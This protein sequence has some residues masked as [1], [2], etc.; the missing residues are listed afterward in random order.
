M[1]CSI[2]FIPS[3]PL[4]TAC[5]AD[6]G[7][8][9]T[10]QRVPSLNL[11]VKISLPIK[12][13]LQAL[14][15]LSEPSQV[16]VP[17]V[18]S[19]G[20]SCGSSQAQTH[21]GSKVPAVPAVSPSPCFS[22]SNVSKISRVSSLT[23]PVASVTPVTP[24]TSVPSKA[25]FGV[26]GSWELSETPGSCSVR[27]SNLLKRTTSQHLQQAFGDVDV[28]PVLDCRVEKGS[29]CLTFGSH[30]DARKAVDRY[31]GGLLEITEIDGSDGTGDGETRDAAEVAS[32]WPNTA[33][34]ECLQDHLGPLSKCSFRGGDGWVTLF[35]S[36]RAQQLKREGGRGAIG[37]KGSFIS[38]CLDSASGASGAP[39]ALSHEHISFLKG[40][41]VD[42]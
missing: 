34:M 33:S 23:Q 41:P 27:V 11:Q 38:V 35:V 37:F 26:S 32:L 39:G 4:S 7:I 40:I 42:L 6:V 21:Q 30:E 13:L 14:S 31:H 8:S 9:A 25:P 3:I 24:V 20:G 29:A 17:P 15:Q 12:E 18:P 5:H 16:S 22:V 36:S 10:G 19:T 28:G 2:P 1:A